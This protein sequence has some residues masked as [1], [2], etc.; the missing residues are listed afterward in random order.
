VH[1]PQSIA[2][3]T[4]GELRVTVGWTDG[5]AH[6]EAAEKGQEAEEDA[7]IRHRKTWIDSLSSV[8]EQAV[9]HTV[10]GDEEDEEEDGEDVEE[11]QPNWGGA[12]QQ[13]VWAGEKSFWETAQDAV[14]GADLDKKEE[15]G[16][17]PG[18]SSEEAAATRRQSGGRKSFWE[19][20]QDAVL[21]SEQLG[22]ATEEESGDEQGEEQPA[23][24]SRSTS[25]WDMLTGEG[26]E[27]PLAPPEADLDSPGQ[28]RGSKTKRWRRAPRDQ[29]AL[30]MKN[31]E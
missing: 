18:A 28:R 11:G 22:E 8:V 2:V 31:D 15:A 4:G 5:S 10:L 20:A 24:R 23:E 25:I 14:L 27:K 19:T 21:G 16:E 13:E 1:E 17:E 7:E 6:A 26:E 12:E 9:V 30:E 3:D 29:S